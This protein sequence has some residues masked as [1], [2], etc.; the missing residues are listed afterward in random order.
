[1][2]IFTTSNGSNASIGENQFENDV[3]VQK[4]KQNWMWFHAQNVPSGH[5]LLETSSPNKK[6]LQEVAYEV[7]K[8]CKGRKIEYCL[9]KYVKRT[10]TP[11]LV[12]LKRRPN[13]IGF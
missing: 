3:L 6:E 5:G 8:R 9:V 7:F 12:L 1:M 4:A 10:T 2:Y 11:G 13:V